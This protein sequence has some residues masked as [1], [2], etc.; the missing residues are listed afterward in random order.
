[1]AGQNNSFEDDS[2]EEMIRPVNPNKHE[3]NDV[4]GGRCRKL[5]HFSKIENA[6]KGKD[7]FKNCQKDLFNVKARQTEVSMM[8]SPTM[9]SFSQIPEE[10]NE[11]SP[12]HGALMDRSMQ[13]CSQTSNSKLRLHLLNCTQ[14]D[15]EDVSVRSRG[16]NEHNSNVLEAP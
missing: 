9:Q 3:S 4:D 16:V 8:D 6:K 2:E 11:E 12:M 1:M 10:N 5:R 7:A 14:D 13:S 15:T